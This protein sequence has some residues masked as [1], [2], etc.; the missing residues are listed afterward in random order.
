[1][2]RPF[3]RWMSPAGA[4][5]PLS[6]LIFHRVLTE[7]DP[8][9]PDEMHARRFDQMC[10]WLA[11]WFNVLPLDQAVAGLKAGNLP[12]RSACITFDDG[13]ADNYRVAMPILRR[14][15]LTATFFIATGF[16]DGGRMWNDTLIESV[17]GCKASQLDLSSLGLPAL[18]L[19]SMDDRKAAIATLINQIKYRPVD[20]RVAV[21][22]RVAR[23]AGVQLPGD[24]MMTSQEVLAMRRAGMQIGAHTVSHPIL[25][26]LSDAQARQEIGDSKQ[27]LERLL[28]ER[29][30]LFAY[31]NGK[32]GEDY[33]PQSVDIVRGLGFDAAV[34]T[35]WGAS[36][37]GDDVFQIR[38]FTPWDNT[39]LRF[40]ARL[41]ANLRGA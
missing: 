40:G 26:R 22:E 32:P 21:T 30:G 20:E 35:T 12:A 38:R 16:L 27:F 1:M 39:R 19:K 2:F 34:S 17:R 33:S 7:P 14:H 31:P 24:L 15:G 4:G 23:Q 37:G 29:V 13:Y 5:A 18:A 11:S 28:G 36:R 9:F 3:F 8:L 6:V 25:A 10:Q 41:L